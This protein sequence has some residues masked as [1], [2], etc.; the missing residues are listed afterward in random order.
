MTI[1]DSVRS[2]ERDLRAIFGDRLDALVIYRPVAD[3]PGLPIPTLATVR[4]LTVDDLR[5][6]AGRVDAWQDAGLA[7]PLVIAA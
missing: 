3:A 5:A 7:T 1:P 6:C 2:L 4:S